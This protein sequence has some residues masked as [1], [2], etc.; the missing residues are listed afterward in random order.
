MALT[1]AGPPIAVFAHANR[2]EATCFWQ[3]AMQ[4]PPSSSIP[5]TAGLELGGRPPGFAHP[6]TE[7]LGVGSG[8][9]RSSGPGLEG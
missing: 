5:V 4:R 7:L 3:A 6:R 2:V 9:L 1:F 8:L